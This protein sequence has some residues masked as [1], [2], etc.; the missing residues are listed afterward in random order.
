MSS[1]TDLSRFRQDAAG[2][3]CVDG[4]VVCVG[5]AVENV[6][7][8]VDDRILGSSDPIALGVA[9]CSVQ[10]GVCC[11]VIALEHK[12]ADFVGSIR[13]VRFVQILECTSF[14]V[15]PAR[16]ASCCCKVEDDLVA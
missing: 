10:V 5:V 1:D 11:G 15:A 14:V 16:S 7:G 12:N 8:V 2:T 3:K 13:A 6:R 4:W 9:T